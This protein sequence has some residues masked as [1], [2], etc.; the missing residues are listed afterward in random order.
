MTLAQPIRALLVEAGSAGGARH[1]A[2]THADACDEALRLCRVKL[3]ADAIRQ[4]EAGACDVVLLDL[5]LPDSQGVSTFMRIRQAAPS[6][7]VLVLAEQSGEVP[8]GGPNA[9]AGEI[10]TQERAAAIAVSLEY[11]ARRQ[12]ER[13][14]RDEGRQQSRRAQELK[15]FERLSLV[16]GTSVTSQIYSGRGLREAAPQEFND[17]LMR[18]GRIL[19]SGVERRIYGEDGGRAEAL[20]ELSNELGF[21]RAGPRDVIEMHCA[22][23]RAKTEEAP[24]RKAHAYF[25]EGRLLVLE[26]MGNLASYYR[27][28]FGMLNPQGSTS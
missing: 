1:E 18:Y 3:L 6:V 22:A 8:D 27:N 21:L 11:A 5:D 28:H 9:P 23:L 10:R 17:M 2:V 16:P 20:R 15:S 4:L 13:R 26:L 24:P 7:P 19:E 25:E 14:E 12:L